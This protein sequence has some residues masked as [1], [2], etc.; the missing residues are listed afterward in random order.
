MLAYILLQPKK[1][2]FKLMRGIK[3]PIC[4]A[5]GVVEDIEEG[6]M[7]KCFYCEAK[8]TVIKSRLYHIVPYDKR[9]GVQEDLDTINLKKCIKELDDEYLLQMIKTIMEELLLRFRKN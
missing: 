3:C 5:I 4:Q 6:E 7:I 8:Y 2:V 9:I 1:G